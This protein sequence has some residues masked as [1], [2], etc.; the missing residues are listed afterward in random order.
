MQSILV[1]AKLHARTR[2]QMQFN[3]SSSIMNISYAHAEFE[4]KLHYKIKVRIYI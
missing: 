1:L 2:A 4:S 3:I